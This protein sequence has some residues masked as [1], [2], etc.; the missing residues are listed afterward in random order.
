MGAP[1]TANL[2]DTLKAGCSCAVFGDVLGVRW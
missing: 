2:C 1:A